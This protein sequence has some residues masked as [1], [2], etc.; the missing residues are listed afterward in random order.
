M[1]DV[2]KMIITDMTGKYL[3]NISYPPYYLSIDHPHKYSQGSFANPTT[4]Y[5]FDLEVPYK[6][7]QV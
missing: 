7:Q 5:I 2:S 6:Y 3:V 1:V 4:L